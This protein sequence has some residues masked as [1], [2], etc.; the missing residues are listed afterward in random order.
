[1][2][3]NKRLIGTV[4]AL[5]RRIGT[6]YRLVLGFNGSL[7]VLGAAGFLPPATSALL[8]NLST[9]GISVQSVTN[10]LT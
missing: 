6:N 10:L 7:I 3:I 4:N 2:M 5:F 9:L 1:M 8:H